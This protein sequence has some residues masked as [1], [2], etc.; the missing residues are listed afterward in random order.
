MTFSNKTSYEYYYIKKI[1]DLDHL[2]SFNYLIMILIPEAYCEKELKFTLRSHDTIFV[3]YISSSSWKIYN[4]MRK[5]FMI[6]HDITFF[7]TRFPNDK[8][9]SHFHSANF[10]ENKLKTLNNFVASFV[11]AFQIPITSSIIKN[12]SSVI[13]NNIIIESSLTAKIFVLHIHRIQRNTESINY[14][15]AMM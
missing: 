14:Y 9:F 6:S 2:Q 10:H 4:L 11:I 12:I 8:K 5:Y 7:E 13:Y 15:N 3:E 1:S